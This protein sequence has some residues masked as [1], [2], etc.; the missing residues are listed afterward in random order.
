MS[1]VDTRLPLQGEHYKRVEEVGVQV[2]YTLAVDRALQTMENSLV[3][4]RDGRTDW[5]RCQ[6]VAKVGCLWLWVIVMAKT[7]FP[8][9][10]DFPLV[11]WR[12]LTWT[13]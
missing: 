10:I 8:F 5:R 9:S 6:A 11:F 3:R 7:I 1:V 2:W 4:R 12:L 13:I